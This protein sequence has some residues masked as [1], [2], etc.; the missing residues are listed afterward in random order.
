MKDDIARPT[1]LNL[2]VS[3]VFVIAA[4][5]AVIGRCQAGADTYRE[6]GAG[7]REVLDDYREQSDSNRRFSEKIRIGIQ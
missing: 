1:S 6:S 3:V 7:M 5:M 4:L 2:I